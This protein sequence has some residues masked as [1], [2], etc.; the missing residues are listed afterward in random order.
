MRRYVN[1]P[2]LINLFLFLLLIASIVV[3]LLL[4]CAPQELKI[5]M[6]CF[7]AL[8]VICVAFQH[9]NIRKKEKQ[10]QKGIQEGTKILKDIL[11][12]AQQENNARQ[13]SVQ[14]VSQPVVSQQ[15]SQPVVSQQPSQPV[16]SQ[17]VVSQQPQ[18]SQPSRPSIWDRI[19]AMTTI[20]P[21]NTRLD[22][23]ESLST[24]RINALFDLMTKTSGRSLFD[25]VE[26]EGK[27]LKESNAFGTFG[28]DPNAFIK[29]VLKVCLD[30]YRFKDSSELSAHVLSLCR[31]TV[32][33]MDYNEFLLKFI[34]D[35]AIPYDPAT[36]IPNEKNIR[37]TGYETYLLQQTN[38]E[39]MGRIQ[40]IRRSLNDKRDKEKMVRL[41][42]ATNEYI[43]FVMQNRQLL[44]DLNHTDNQINYALN[45]SLFSL[46]L[47]IMYGLD[48]VQK[49]ESASD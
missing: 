38:T 11:E 1:T 3:I 42:V 15:P 33:N 9:F 26:D 13:K 25:V 18:P 45:N 10:I 23:N 16:V 8:G 17:P 46:Y 40:N 27:H 21:I 29:N 30:G 28:Y 7:Y 41:V 37:N 32:W 34:L 44:K 22:N 12:Q 47:S 49:K 5:A 24:D 39:L 19:S 20:V 43:D 48:S 35:K 6:S 4:E 2:R 36:T 14:P 31:Q